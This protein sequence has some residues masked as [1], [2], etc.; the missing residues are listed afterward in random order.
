MKT[1]TL[2]AIAAATF[3][4]AT[5]ATLPVFA[6]DWTDANGNEYTALEYIKG[7]SGP[8]VITDFRLAGTDTVKFRFQPTTVSDIEN[9]FCSRG[10][11]NANSISC[12]CIYKTLAVD[13][14]TR[15]K[16]GDAFE[17]NNDYTV[18]IDLN[19]GTTTTGAVTVNGIGQ[20]LDGVLG[21]TSYEAGSCLVLFAA[22]TAGTGLSPSSSFSNKSSSYFYYFQIYS[23]AGVLIHNLMPAQNSSGTAGF[24]DTVGRKF[25]GPHSGAFASAARGVTGS[26]KKWTGLGGDNKMSTGAN[27]EGGVAPGEGDDL[28]FTLAPPHAEIN[29]D[30]S[31][32]TFGKL[33]IDD[34]DL[35][36][37]T[38]SMTVSA[39]NL[40]AKVADISAIT[41]PV[42]D[43]T[44]NG[45]A[46]ANWG[47]VGIWIYDGGAATWADNNNAIFNTAATAT[48]D[49]DVKAVD[50]V[51][52]ADATITTNAAA[53]AL[54][55]SSVSVDSGV[56]ATIDAPIAGALEKK[57]AGTLVLSQDRTNS[58]VLAEGTLALAGTASL[59]WS[60]F[61]FGTDP[62]KPVTLD[63]GPTATLANVPLQLKIGEVNGVTN[64]VVKRGGDVTGITYFRLG[65]ASDAVSTFL[66]EGGDLLSSDYFLVGGGG[67]ALSTLTVADGTVGC[68]T[69][70]SQ[71]VFVG[72]TD[73]GILNV[74]NTGVFTV[75]KSLFV[76]NHANGTLN[77]SDGGHVVAGGDVVF[78]FDY[79]ATISG[80]V[81]LGRGGVLEANSAYRFKDGGSATFNFDGG[82][83]KWYGDTTWLSASAVG[84]LF[85]PNG[86]DKAVDVTVSANG[87]TID[88]SGIVV[89]IPRTITG[90]GG[91]TLVGA[92]TTLISADQSY[93]GTT[94][95]SN[96][97]T[98]AVSGV[99]LAGPLA[100]DTGSGL[101][102]TNY[103]GVTAVSA[104]SLVFPPS[105]TVP[106]TLNGGA[107]P[108][109]AYSICSATGVTAAEGDKFAF[110]T[111]DGLAGAWSVD[112]DTL[113]L[114]VG[115]VSGNYW[116]GRGGDGRMS[117]AGNWFDGSSPVDGEDVDFSGVSSATTIIAD[118]A[119]ATFGTV[120]MGDGVITFTNAITA[121]NFT[122]TSKISVGADSTVTVVGD[123][124]ISGET[125]RSIVYTIAVSGRFV[126]TGDIIATEDFSA[127]YLY[128]SA[129]ASCPG[130][131]VARGLVNRGTGGRSFCL[132][133]DSSGSQVTW[134]IGDHGISSKGVPGTTGAAGYWCFDRSNSSATI[135]ADADFTI[136]AW[137]TNREKLVLNTTGPDGTSHTITVG[138]GTTG[139]LDN[140]CWLVTTGAGK[141]LFNCVST[142]NGGLSVMGTS[143]LAV[144]SGCRPGNNLIRLYEGTTFEVAQAGTVTLSNTLKF[145][146]GTTL[147]F[148][149]TDRAEPPVL[150][151]ADGK[152]ITATG[153]V[154]VNISS[155]NEVRPKGG[156]YVL[157]TCGGF[158]AEGVTVSLAADAP[159]WAAGR[160]SVNSDGNIVLEVKPRGTMIVIR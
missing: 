51:F 66:N 124:E 129:T 118:I 8:C 157:T 126:V 131:F 109:G 121:A 136:A 15:R 38:G 85:Y 43:Y 150:A 11:G 62:A 40:P 58:T 67:A 95:V 134:V 77:I 127:G 18:M 70:A 117:T 30:I 45:G 10:S 82:T 137:L 59:D 114:T 94:T 143:T 44:W 78:C 112:G 19:V 98:L 138:N 17:A 60:G 79:L 108:E 83:F 65:Y 7:T 34:G 2:A 42:G 50:V 153:A 100:F 21:T 160:L 101:E 75:E 123:L 99:S 149:F 80:V 61:T 76:A 1:S 57:G 91:M 23:S 128:P 48:L 96:G 141:V 125:N 145:D 120:T 105:G 74:T 55:A 89:R 142:F 56:S 29:A 64:T 107:F 84:G 102:V 92:G 133:S 110:T 93:L 36:T 115:E 71:R 87:G 104:T 139:L 35:P 116:T 25:Y 33:W 152:T 155:A 81:N 32:V 69:S 22:H 20:T 3:A 49:S 106:L 122:D 63:I 6:S 111:T 54:A 12:F 68:T 156:T 5:S 97:T 154:T 26:G 73:E 16:T 132:Y 28:D 4:V 119:N 52:N 159:N 47:D 113:I 37:F 135:I 144:N 88:N 14:P 27:W 151:V 90:V 103:V 86:N 146:S 158:D 147:A 39:V 140:D 53:H 41:V 9:V 24:Y 72:H 13:R 46:S 148:N 130:T 31:G